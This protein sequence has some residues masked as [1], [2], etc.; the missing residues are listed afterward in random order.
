MDKKDTTM[1]M[2]KISMTA[3]VDRS[4]ETLYNLW[5]LADEILEIGEITD[6]LF[7]KIGKALVAKIWFWES[8]GVKSECS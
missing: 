6:V 1:W 7:K 2:P 4:L 5:L 8:L 3:L